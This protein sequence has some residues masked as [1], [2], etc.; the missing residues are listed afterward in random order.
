MCAVYDDYA[1]K[2]EVY[3]S[4]EEGRSDCEA[5]ELAI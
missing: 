4:T 1:A 5:N 3:R 2:A